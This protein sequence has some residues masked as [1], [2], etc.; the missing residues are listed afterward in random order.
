MN[1]H[2]ERK[3]RM[4]ELL[5]AEIALTNLA[6][7]PDLK[8]YHSI[9]IPDA[10]L[11]E[12]QIANIERIEKSG[13]KSPEARTLILKILHDKRMNN[14]KE[15]IS[16]SA[17]MHS[18]KLQNELTEMMTSYGIN[19]DMEIN[20]FDEAIYNQP[21]DY[22]SNKM[23]LCDLLSDDTTRYKVVSIAPGETL[24]VVNS[25]KN[26]YIKVHVPLLSDEE[27]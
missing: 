22:I 9:Y 20:T 14:I 24:N 1:T 26:K 6:G 4:G 16:M 11:S 25:N 27:V 13:D 15:I 18:E 3:K 12:D 17:I 5:K 21:V 2:D 10:G 23:H 7:V 19:G 8:I